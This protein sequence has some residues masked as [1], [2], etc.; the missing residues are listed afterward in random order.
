MPNLPNSTFRVLKF[1]AGGFSKTPAIPKHERYGMFVVLKFG[2]GHFQKILQTKST[3][4]RPY[5]RRRC[6]VKVP[7][8]IIF[9]ENSGIYYSSSDGLLRVSISYRKISYHMPPP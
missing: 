7:N 9:G 6:D 2:A 5:I 8:E 3:I 4:S 1:G